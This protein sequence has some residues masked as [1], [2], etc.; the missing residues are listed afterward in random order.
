MQHDQSSDAAAASKAPE[1]S[2]Q[3]ATRNVSS[4]KSQTEETTAGYGPFRYWVNS[5]LRNKQAIVTLGD[6]EWYVTE[7][8][9]D[10]RLRLMRVDGEGDAA[11]V[12]FDERY[13]PDLFKQIL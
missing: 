12:P 3:S 10:G 7:L 5:K 2:S 4:E 8:A 9:P 1:H 6:S 13:I 11:L